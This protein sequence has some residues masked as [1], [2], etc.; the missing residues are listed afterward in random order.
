MVTSGKQGG[1]P[2]LSKPG[3][4]TK[5]GNLCFSDVG[6]PRGRPEHDFGTFDID[7]VPTDLIKEKI[8]LTLMGVDRDIIQMHI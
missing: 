8:R 3:I 1:N 5:N 4:G 7:K 6:E 2:V